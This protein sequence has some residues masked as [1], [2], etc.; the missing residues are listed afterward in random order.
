MFRLKYPI[1]L[2]RG[3]ENDFKLLGVIIMRINI[4]CDIKSRLQQIERN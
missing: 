4:H 2:T 1:I 3:T